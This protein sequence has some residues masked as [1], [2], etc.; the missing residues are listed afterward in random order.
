MDLHALLLGAALLG[1]A[2]APAPGPLCSIYVTPGRDREDTYFL[3]TALEGTRLTGVGPMRAQIDSSRRA[4][5][6][7][8]VTGQVL[9]LERVGGAG[10]EV[11]ER[12]FRETGRREALVIP[13]TLDGVNCRPSP[14]PPRERWLEPGTRGVLVAR[15]RPTH[16]WVDGM[17]TFD[18]DPYGYLY[19]W[20]GARNLGCPG[21]LTAEEWYDFLDHLGPR[22]PASGEEDRRI[23]AHFLLW[24][25]RHP[26]VALRQ[27]AKEA[28]D[29]PIYLDDGLPPDVGAAAAAALARCGR[30]AAP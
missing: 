8:Q 4:R 29:T 23:E 5:L 20:P 17:P 1:A 3:A 9:R 22:Y 16:L 28:L 24:L 21:A 13:W 10:S 18:A 12:V 25:R 19:P 2:P 11:V 26:D 27:P 6:P 30:A 14:W 15:L 7:G